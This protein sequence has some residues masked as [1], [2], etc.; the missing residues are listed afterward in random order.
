[1]IWTGRILRVTALDT[2]V[3]YSPPLEEYFLPN[4]K[5]VRLAVAKEL[6]RY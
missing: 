5:K 1:M 3:P 4:A 6:A 2:P